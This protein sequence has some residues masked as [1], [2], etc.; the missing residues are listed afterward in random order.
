MPQRVTRLA[1]G[2]WI[3]AII[4]L[5]L[6][7]AQLAQGIR[8]WPS[9]AAMAVALV[10]V[11]LLWLIRRGVIHA[12][13]REA[14]AKA[15]WAALFDAA[16]LGLVRLDRS[17]SI[18]E[19]NQHFAD[20]YA[21]PREQLIGRHGFEDLEQSQLDGILAM[22]DQLQA[23]QCVA[24]SHSWEVHKQGEPHRAR[25]TG[26][27]ARRADG[28]IDHLIFIIEDLTAQ[29]QAERSLA[30]RERQ[31]AESEERFRAIFDQAPVGIAYLTLD[32][33]WE[34]VNR[35]VCELLQYDA[36]E[37]IGQPLLSIPPRPQ[38]INGVP[39]AELPAAVVEAERARLNHNW[40]RLVE[41]GTPV[42]LEESFR[43]RDGSAVWLRSS[44]AAVHGSDGRPRF[45]V[46][47]VEEITELK[48]AEATA[49]QL[50]LYD[51]LTELPN[52]RLLAD[53][54]AQS[55]HAC[56]RTGQQ[57]AVLFIDLDNFKNLNDARGHHEGDRLLQQLGE[58]LQ[59]GI[60]E[61]DTVARLGGDEFVVVLNNL[62]STPTEASLAAERVAKKLQLLLAQSLTLGDTR[63]YPSASFGISLFPR[64]GLGS[65][66]EVLKEA[67]TAMYRAK[68]ERSGIA[69]YAAEMQQFAEQRLALER[70][71]HG[72]VDNGELRLYLQPQVD[73]AGGLIGAEALLRWQHPTRGL[74]PPDEFIPIAEECGL[75]V[76]VGRWVL[77]QA[78][79]IL[80]RSAELPR[81]FSLSVNVSPRQ[82]R[83]PGFT[84]ELAA[85]L[86]ETGVAPERLTIEITEGLMIELGEEIT[87][88]M[89]AVQTLGVRLSID[90]FGTGWSSLAYLK[91]LPLHELKI[92]RIFVSGLPED[93]SD[94]AIVEAILALARHLKLDVV[95]EGV[96]TAA[97]LDFLTTRGCA[98]FQGYH[99]GR[100]EPQESFLTRVLGEGP[101]R[102]L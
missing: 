71:L 89:A 74:L 99:L 6:T 73:T 52:R 14:A 85:I 94:G 17:H 20:S 90:D 102:T 35:R 21:L 86:A 5:L 82:F 30:E 37:F 57:G 19:A 96:E 68:K 59:H 2:A 46:L 28:S 61:Q 9:A 1:A 69:F 51:P 38:Q 60:R 15:E 32:G 22:V 12:M 88:R 13:A 10:L 54:L 7:I 87:S 34:M 80:R 39:V 101:Q 36:G 58:R 40:L 11:G 8:L 53:R 98:Y 18:L 25:T 100:P 31:L 49:R 75:I 97:Q 47:I 65:Y 81:P 41:Y 50:A 42:H 62:G 44:T 24:A 66:D 79:E 64:A 45:L 93:Q 55:V 70:D 26:V 83:E 78:C 27:A 23:G 48:N 92:D 76:P 63:Y 67:D 29:L 84:R 95:A 3:A 16:G 4:L 72:A 91:R 33:R 56:H 43:R 77:L